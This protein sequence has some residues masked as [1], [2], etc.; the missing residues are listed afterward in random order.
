MRLALAL[1]RSG[2]VVFGLLFVALAPGRAAEPATGT[3]KPDPRSVRWHGPAYRYPQAGWIVVHIEGEPYE[4][5]YQHGQLLAP[6]IV[7]YLKCFAAMQNS[8]APIE[9]WKTVRTLVNSLFVR[10]FEREFL[11]EM[12]GIADGA[13]AAGAR[14]DDRPL[15]LVDI[16]GINCWAEIETLDAALEATPTG[17]EGIRFAK[18]QPQRPAPP[19]PMH[20]SAFAATGPATADGKIVFGHVTMFNLYPSLFYNVWLDVKPAKGNRI[21]MASYPGG[22][23][24]GMD[25]YINSAGILL[26]ETTINQ[27]RFNINGLTVANRTRR[28]MQYGNSIDQAVDLLQK[29]N[30]GLYT[31]EWMLADIHTNEIAMFE[32]GTTKS[33]L[34]RSSKGEWFVG[35][36]GFYW[37]CNNV[38]DLQVRLD[39]VASV[40]GRPANMVFRPT[41]RDMRWLEL[42]SQHKGKIN[43]EFGKIAFQTTPICSNVTLDAK[44]TTSSMAKELRSWA[45]FGPPRGKSWQPTDEE[46]KDFPEIRPL[47]SNPWTLLHPEAPPPKPDIKVVDLP[48]KIEDSSGKDKG[49]RRQSLLRTEDRSTTVAAWHGTIL[50]KTDADIWLAVAFAEYEKIVAMENTAIEKAKD[51]KLSAEDKDQLAL[52]IFAHRSNY[53]AA[54][55]IRGDVPL[56]KTRAE[57]GRDDWYRIASGK[58]VLLLHELRKLIGNREFQTLMEAFGRQHAGK[59]VSTA[60][61]VSHVEAT[62]GG[63]VKSFFDAWLMQTG[64]PGVNHINGVYSVLS[65]KEEPQQTLIVFGTGDEEAANRETA[66]TLQESIRSSWCHCH[67]TVRSD[68]EVT[69]S[70]LKT[71]H[72]LLIG[73]PDCSAVVRRF[74]ASLPVEFGQRSF[75]VRGDAYAHAGSGII[76][77]AE[78]P[79]NRR[80]SMVVLAGLSAEATTKLPAALLKKDQQAAE[81]IVLPH[82]GA[83][84]LLVLSV[85]E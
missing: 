12:K 63:K 42:Y 69:E 73:R 55:R 75:V 8:K 5:G 71:H 1:L 16:V 17:L 70:E 39:T 26:L 57:L 35:T 78:N 58:G 85:G 53:L 45:L 38:R 59:H 13:A 21:V 47:V 20:C 84:K 74:Q 29:D 9:G 37:G 50:P 82:G 41:D 2:L 18:P 4:R 60:Q 76:V 11:E 80:Y 68:R 30:N 31:N 23:Q 7:G 24:S 34:W 27:T 61:F 72:L 15:D 66:E 43:G 49:E 19:R 36:E 32:L 62:A 54:S 51:G 65:F 44:V 67:L 56:A 40:Q 46:K 77:A 22:I 79:A 6:E 52:E 25:Y 81:A 10:K 48:D 64:V 3:F 28:A 83:A 14:F 33:K